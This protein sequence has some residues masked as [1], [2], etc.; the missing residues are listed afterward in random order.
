LHELPPFLAE[1]PAT[2]TSDVT[3]SNAAANIDAT[4]FS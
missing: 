4:I 3:T 1:A 2:N